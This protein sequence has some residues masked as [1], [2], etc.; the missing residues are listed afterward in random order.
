M[1]YIELIK[2]KQLFNLKRDNDS[3]LFFHIENYMS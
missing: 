1:Y 2:F 3:D